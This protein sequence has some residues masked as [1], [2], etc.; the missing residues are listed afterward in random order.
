[1][2][3]TCTLESPLG[4]LLLVSSKS[5]LTRLVW[6]ADAARLQRAPPC[7]SPV[8]EHAREELIAYFSGSKQGFTVPI[9]PT[10]TAFQNMVWQSLRTLP[11]GQTTSYGELASGVGKPQGAR[12]VGGA[13]GANPIPIIIPCHRVLR[14]GN[15]LGG[16]SGGLAIKR[17]LLRLEEIDWQ[18]NN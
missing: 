18:E 8:L 7:Q 5:K 1:M 4:T 9:E 14:V 10:G 12:A 6:G 3:E 13:V 11:H 17:Q 2:T 15:R 16:F